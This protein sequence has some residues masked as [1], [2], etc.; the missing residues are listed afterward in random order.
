MVISFTFFERVCTRKEKRVKGMTIEEGIIE[1]KVPLFDGVAQKA[2][3][4][5]WHAEEGDF[6]DEGDDLVDLDVNGE[7]VTLT[8]P[9]AG[10]LTDIFY[11]DDD[12]VESRDVIAEI[13]EE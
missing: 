2:T 4:L 6:V 8:A 10:T 5:S 1:V 13:E 11:G 7:T 9:A 12:A 3:L